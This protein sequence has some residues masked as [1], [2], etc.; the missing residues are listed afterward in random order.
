M[1]PA[2]PVS[3]PKLKPEHIAQAT[4]PYW[5]GR[6]E[7]ERGVIPTL[8]SAYSSSLTIED[9]QSILNWM[10]FQRG[11]LAG[12]LL[13]WVTRWRQNGYSADATLGMLT[14]TLSQMWR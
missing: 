10:R 3:K 9:L 2:S 1:P 12:Y 6:R 14:D 11:E 13:E 4:R 5:Q 8:L 7:E